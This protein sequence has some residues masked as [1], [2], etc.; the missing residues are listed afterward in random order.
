MRD[1][2]QIQLCSNAADT[3]HYTGRLRTAN[4]RHQPDGTIP[5]Q[6]AAPVC[7]GRSGVLQLYDH[8]E[9][10]LDPAVGHGRGW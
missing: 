4:P 1:A 2:G 7:T 5:I 9:I 3:G 6:R 10:N 8:N